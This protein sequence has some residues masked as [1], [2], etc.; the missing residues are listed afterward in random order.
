MKKIAAILVALC[1]FC[2]IYTIDFLIITGIYY[3]IACFCLSLAFSWKV[4]LAI[5]ICILAFKLIFYKKEQ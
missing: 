3:V 5:W 2:M 1:L 4:A